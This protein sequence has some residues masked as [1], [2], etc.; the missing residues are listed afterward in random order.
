MVS[1]EIHL[2]YLLLEERPQVTILE[3]T[4]WSPEKVVMKLRAPTGNINPVVHTTSS[5]CSDRP[6]PT[7]KMK[8]GYI[9]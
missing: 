6:I 1:S 2:P 4:G 7:S 5:H 9:N 3:D 8:I